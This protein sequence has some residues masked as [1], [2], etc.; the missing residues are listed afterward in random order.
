MTLQRTPI[1]SALGS[2]NM[3]DCLHFLLCYFFMFP[4]NALLDSITMFMHKLFNHS[5]N[6]CTNFRVTFSLEYL[7]KVLYSLDAPICNR[8]AYF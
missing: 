6:F 7:L 1:E 2:C 5:L 4:I 8:I 3:M